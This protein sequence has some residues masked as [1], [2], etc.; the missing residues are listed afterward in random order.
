[1]TDEG[2]QVILDS[3]SGQIHLANGMLLKM[4]KDHKQGLLEFR[5]DTWQENVMIMSTS[6]LEDVDE[7]FEQTESRAEISKQQLW[8]ECLGHPG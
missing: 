6:L 2:A 7:D 5:G 8:H 4:T 1:M 3:A